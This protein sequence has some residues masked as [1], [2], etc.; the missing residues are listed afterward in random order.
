MSKVP[1][2]FAH[3]WM[4]SLLLVMPALT[5]AQ[6]FASWRNRRVLRRLG[7]PLTLMAQLPSPRRFAWLAAFLFGTGVTALIMG[8]A[9]PHWG[10]E[11]HPEVVA[12]RDLVILLDM[13]KSMRA[14]D[15]PPDRFHRSV[16]ALLKMIDYIRLRGGH[17]LGLVVFAADAQVIC[18]LT[19]DC[20]HVQM[21][22]E[23]LDMDYPPPGLRPRSNSQSGTRIGLGLRAAVAIHEPGFAGFQDVLLVSDGDDPQTDGEWEAALR[24]VLPSGVPISAIGVGDPMHDN[25]IAVSGREGK[26]KTRLIEKPLQEISRRTAGQYLAAGVE[27]PRL[28]EFFRHKIES[29]GGTVPEGD[30]PAL[31]HRRQAWFYAAALGL[32][33]L[34]GLVRFRISDIAWGKLKKEIER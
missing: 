23:A 18:P 34:A 27:M 11:E 8:A 2:I 21:K 28:D 32:F 6:L 4:L 12:G 13:S 24:D 1:A 26:V 14:T 5:V 19:H 3:P 17:R 15:A 31:P 29:K 7:D 33:A 25:E 10:Q 30:A 9:G 20:R 22:L 16:Q